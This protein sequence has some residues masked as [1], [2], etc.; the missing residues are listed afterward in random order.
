MTARDGVMLVAVVAALG[1]SVLAAVRWLRVAQRE[2]YL[3]GSATRFA[4]RWW[5]GFGPNRLLGAAAVVGVA[6]SPISPVAAIAAALAISV[7]PFRLSL[8]GRAPGKL[9]WTARLRRLAAVT[10]L[11]VIVPVGA[12]ALLG[13]AVPVSALAALIA[14][15]LVDL[16]CMVTA[17]IEDR[18]AGRFVEQASARLHKV[19]PTVVGITGSY[20]KTSTKVYAAH[21]CA[22]AKRVVP[23]PASFNN[24]AGLSRAI[25][26]HLSP[27]T[28]VFLAEMGTYGPGEIRALCSWCPPRIAAI[29]AIGPVHLERFGSEEAVLSAKSEIFEA[30]SVAV[31]NVDDP[32]LAAVAAAQ[33][34]AGLRVWRCSSIDSAAD[35]C[36]RRD[37]EKLVVT[38]RGE[39]LATVDDPAAQAGNV[40]VAVAIALEVGVAGDLVARALA[41]LP[42]V[43]NRQAVTPLS[44]GAVAID[45]TF[46][47]N[48]AGSRAALATLSRL[49]RL[50][51]QKVVVTPGMVELG[52]RQAEENAA[53]GAA[54]ADV[55]THVIVVG[56]TNRP[57]LLAG[58]ARATNPAAVRVLAV[59]TR[60]QAVAWVRANTAEGDVVLY[61][62]DL[63]DH[64]P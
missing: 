28:E 25:N 55:A 48:P 19:A 29:T 2:H 10:A 17:P 50:G 36:S 43:A 16:G 21:L 47:A 3:P 59:D 12:A 13:A 45:D 23:S 49:A 22:A 61:E 20:G 64:Y 60:D 57:A 54:L 46:N 9:V 6:L 53:L 63:P 35:V 62:N 56:W 26:E 42:Q 41:S 44:S 40:A 15:V 24:R 7:G 27:G 52:P 31:L 30:A 33:E 8:R 14:P 34:R 1:A 11:L 32:R 18:L 4:A 51:G 37:G 5:L 39:P 38:Y 58:L